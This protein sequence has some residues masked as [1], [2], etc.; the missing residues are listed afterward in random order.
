MFLSAFI[1][2][3]NQKTDGDGKLGLKGG[4]DNGTLGFG[5]GKRKRKSNV[6]CWMR[7]FDVSFTTN[8]WSSALSFS[9]SLETSMFESREEVGESISCVGLWD[10]GR[11]VWESLDCFRSLKWR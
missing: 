7:A 1:K 3:Q 4:G 6:H 8:C 9:E 2:K 10:G 11:L 5:G